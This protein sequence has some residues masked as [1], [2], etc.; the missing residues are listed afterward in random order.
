MT[1]NGKFN[2]GVAAQTKSAKKIR[3]YK[4]HIDQMMPAKVTVFVIYTE[5]YHSN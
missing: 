1:I 5:N 3:I 2:K 4:L